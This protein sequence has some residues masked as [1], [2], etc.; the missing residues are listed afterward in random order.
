V[1][2]HFPDAETASTKLESEGEQL[3]DQAYEL[4]AAPAFE[5]FFFVTSSAPIDQKRVL[6]AAERLARTRDG[7]RRTSLALKPPLH[8]HSLMLVKE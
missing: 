7:A 8:Q 1:T 2:L 5:R 3:L 6:I 4:D